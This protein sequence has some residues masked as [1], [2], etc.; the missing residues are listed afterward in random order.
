M[1]VSSQSFK[2]LSDLFFS[3]YNESKF[4]SEFTA[5]RYVVLEVDNEDKSEF[6]F[7]DGVDF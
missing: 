6:E 5:P 3:T 1:N 4:D 7:N 2:P